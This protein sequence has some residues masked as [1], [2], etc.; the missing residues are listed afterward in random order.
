M[1]PLPTPVLIVLNGRD[2]PRD[3]VLN[4]ANLADTVY[5]ADGAAE[6]LLPDVVPDHIVGDGDSLPQEHLEAVDYM[7]IDDQETSDCDKVLA[8]AAAHGHR[9]VHVIGIEGDRLDHVLYALQSCANSDLEIELILRTGR[10]RVLRPG[11]HP[12]I[13]HGTFS[14]MPIHE[15]TIK[16]Q[17]AAWNVDGAGMTSISNEATG[18]FAIEVY[19]GAALLVLVDSE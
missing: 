18:P 9:A 3:T 17:N 4:W 7:L 10:G 19:S 1:K 8:L 13:H 6:W 16:I 11:R 5:A 2:M 15:G 12:M 14:I